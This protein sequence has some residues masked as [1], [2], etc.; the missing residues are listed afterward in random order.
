MRKRL[1]LLAV[2]AVSGLVAA[3]AAWAGNPHFLRFDDPTLVYTGASASASAAK[4]SAPG[5]SSTSDPRVFVGNIVVAGVQEGVTTHLTAPFEAVYVCVNGGANVPN[6]AN[7]TTLI[8]QLTTSADF[9]AARNGRA[10]GSLLTGP[11]PSVAAAAAATGFTCPSGQR[12][13]FDR[14]IFSGLVLAV[15]GGETATLGARLVSTS[16]HG[17][18]G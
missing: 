16:V 17:L 6:A 15:D 18:T 8:G 10:T 13:E 9:P 4:A 14:V 2:V 1:T 12:L 7:K 5:P 11:L 3:V